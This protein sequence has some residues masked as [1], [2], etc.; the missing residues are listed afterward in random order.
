MIELQHYNK[1]SAN[2]GGFAPAVSF[3][4]WI[5]AHKEKWVELSGHHSAAVF[6]IKTILDTLQS[7]NCVSEKDL[8]ASVA[9]RFQ[10]LNIK[11]NLKGGIAGM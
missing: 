6:L 11:T 10:D 8:R 5:A 1:A 7:G 2:S 4:E 9:S 3:D